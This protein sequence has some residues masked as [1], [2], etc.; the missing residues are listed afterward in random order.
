MRE[1]LSWQVFQTHSN[2][3]ERHFDHQPFERRL[4]LSVWSKS[5]N[6]S[7]I[8]KYN[9]VPISDM[10]VDN[11]LK[12]EN[13]SNWVMQLSCCE[14]NSLKNCIITLKKKKSFLVRK[15]LRF[16]IYKCGALKKKLYLR[17]CYCN[18]LETFL[19]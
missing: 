6:A 19:I 15:I 17:F 16:I 10:K 13:L 3:L 1:T 18:F 14:Q 5:R 12:M 7:H 2:S 9:Y 8:P 4:Y 11:S